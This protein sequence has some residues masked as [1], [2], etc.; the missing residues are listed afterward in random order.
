MLIVLGQQR[1]KR[2]LGVVGVT[3]EEG[4]A[5]RRGHRRLRKDAVS[6]T[7]PM[8]GFVSGPRSAH[9]VAY[10]HGDG[11][12]AGFATHSRFRLRERFY[13]RARFLWEGLQARCLCLRSPRPERKASGL[14]ALL[15]TPAANARG[16]FETTQ[17]R[18][19]RRPAAA[20]SRAPPTA[21]DAAPRPK[22]SDSPGSSAPPVRSAS[23]G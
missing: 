17:D 22:R 13:G 21:T 23:P 19:E 2:A 11:G 4:D 12:L 1:R 7:R 16:F 18:R 20:I 5:W 6:I 3:G 8:R 10:R 9:K 15:K 14:K